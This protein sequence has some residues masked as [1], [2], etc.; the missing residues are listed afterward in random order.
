MP[1]C[2]Q[3]TAVRGCL[4]IFAH[5]N[6]TVLCLLP[7]T[8]STVLFVIFI[9]L[10][11]VF[12]FH[13]NY[14]YFIPYLIG[15]VHASLTKWLMFF[16]HLVDLV[17]WFNQWR[18]KFGSFPKDLIRC[19]WNEAICWEWVSEVAILQ[20]VNPMQMNIVFSPLTVLLENDHR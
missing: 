6:Y 4:L 5:L 1:H 3:M 7:L 10:Q 13:P 15:S 19:Q 11:S 18:I 8:H 16:G 2:R 9:S 17:Q 14:C 12:F 20:T